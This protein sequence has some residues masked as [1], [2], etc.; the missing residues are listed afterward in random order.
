MTHDFAPVA[1]RQF[2]RIARAAV[3]ANATAAGTGT[4]TGG[5]AAAAAAESTKAAA[6][7]KLGTEIA[8]NQIYANDLALALLLC[9]ALFFLSA[10]P[11]MSVWFST[12]RFTQGWVLGGRKKERVEDE[13]SVKRGM[14]RVVSMQGVVVPAA[15]NVVS[16]WFAHSRWAFNRFFLPMVPVLD[17]T[18]G[19]VLVCATYQVLV[20]VF[21]LLNSGPLE[22]N[23]LRP[24]YI[25]VAQIPAVYLLATKNSVLSVIGKSYEKLNFL[26]RIAGRMMIVCGIL[27]SVLYFKYS[28][29]AGRAIEWSAPLIYTGM[30]AFVAM[31]LTLITSISY[32]RRAFYQVFL[33]SHIIGWLTFIIA[34]NYHVTSGMA[35]PYTVVGLGGLGLDFL[36]RL[37]HTRWRPANIM[38]LSGGMTMIQVDGV[39]QGWRAGQHVWVRVLEGRRAGEN[40]PFTIANA[41]ADCSPLPGSHSLTL[42]AQSRGDWTQSLLETATAA[43][44]ITEK[45]QGYGRTVNVSI[46]GPY[47]GPMFTDFSESQNVVLIAGGSGITFAASVLEEIVGQAVDGTCRT[48]TVTLVWSVKNIESIDW[49]QDFL[50]KLLEIARTRTCLEVRVLIHVTGP[51]VASYNPIRDAKIRFHRPDLASLIEDNVDEVLLSIHRKQVDEYDLLPARG[52]GIA[53]GTC[54]PTALVRSARSAIAGVAR[55]RAVGAGGIVAHTECFG[56]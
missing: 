15:I 10:A 9:L 11:S 28:A 24:G 6:A 56:W 45:S 44:Q 2:H 50:N 21:L 16:A 53:V 40:H 46:E 17:L 52:G 35:R 37:V 4:R 30:V 43:D 36:L 51:S 25:S 5:A 13:W 34:I 20:F 7:A 22:A 29:D 39:A 8:F 31:C 23:Y 27:H 3:N 18:V 38:A 14:H 47:G 32:F 33:I 55:K 12:G 26:H 19:Q 42:L 48:R 41:P 1:L 54:G 49:Y